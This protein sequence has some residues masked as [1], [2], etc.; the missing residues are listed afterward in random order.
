MGKTIEIDWS[1]LR[2]ASGPYPPEAFSFVQQGLRFTVDKLRAMDETM[3]T[4]GRHV[5]GQELCHGLRDFAVDQYGQLARLVLERWNVR[6]TED[7]GKIVFGMVQAG[8]LRKTD[9]DRIEDF[10]GVFDF[11]EAFAEPQ[12]N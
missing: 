4:E 6:R 5:S 11:D 2:A 10:T 3:P 8:L 9:E 12:M 1:A 7:F